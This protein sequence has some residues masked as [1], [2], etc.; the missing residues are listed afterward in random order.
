MSSTKK[1]RMSKTEK[2]VIAC[3]FDGVLHSFT[4]GWKSPCEIPDSPVAGAIHWLSK[5]IDSAHLFKVIIF[6]GRSLHDG[7]TDAMKVWLLRHGITP[8]Q[9]SKLEFSIKKPLCNLLIDDRCFCFT[10]KFPTLNE[11]LAFKPWHGKDIW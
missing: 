6:S 5:L 11:L 9:L 7:G 4:S 1:I 3:D 8:R 2:T 10:G